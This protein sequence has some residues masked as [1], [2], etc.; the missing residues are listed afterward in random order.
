[1]DDF[2]QYRA[3]MNVALVAGSITIW[4]L[5]RAVDRLDQVQSS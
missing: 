1:M 2:D 5:R 4:H 3:E